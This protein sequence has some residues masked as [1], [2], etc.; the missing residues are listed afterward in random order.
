MKS[1]DPRA[2]SVSKVGSVWVVQPPNRNGGRPD[3][4]E[5]GGFPLPRLFGGMSDSQG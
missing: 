3:L 4:G 1:T 2:T 5:M